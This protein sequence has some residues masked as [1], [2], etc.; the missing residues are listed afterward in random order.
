MVTLD[1]KYS[2]LVDELELLNDKFNK[3]IHGN[4]DELVH[5]DSGNIKTLSGTLKDLKSFKYIQRVINHRLYSDMVQDNLNIEIGMLIRIWGDSINGLYKKDSNTVFTKV[6]Y[7]DLY[8]LRDFLPD[9]WNYINIKKDESSFNTDVTLITSKINNS[10]VDIESK[11]L[12]GNVVFDINS[13]NQRGSYSFDFVV[14]ISTGG[15]TEPVANIIKYN[16]STIAIDAGFNT[17]TKPN[18]VLQYLY[19]TD[20]TYYTYKIVAE[21]F[22]ND[23][24]LPLEGR[25][26]INFSQ[27]NKDY[28]L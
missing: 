27:I 6:S 26:D 20:T 15:L 25:L 1:E 21:S 2:S 4:S 12:H 16:V 10:F 9:P 8:D 17:L 23:L 11:R 13:P 22:K 19:S 28:L 5:T 7:S 24:G 3:F 14:H 18:L